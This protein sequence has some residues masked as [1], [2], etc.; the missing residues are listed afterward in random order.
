MPM[1]AFQQHCNDGWK[2]APTLV[3]F[4]CRFMRL[5][6]QS[7]LPS[8]RTVRRPW[9]KFSSGTTHPS[10]HGGDTH[11]SLQGPVHGVAKAYG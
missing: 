1:I 8:T 7:P 11:A 10:G 9:R 6:L 3:S 5:F 4:L 2:F